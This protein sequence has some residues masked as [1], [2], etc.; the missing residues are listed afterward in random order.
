MKSRFGW[1]LATLAIMTFALGQSSAAAGQMVIAKAASVTLTQAAAVRA[2][3]V[4]AAP[5]SATDETKVPHYFGPYPNW[6][7]SPQVLSNAVVDI[8]LGTPTPVS[9]GNPLVERAFATDF[10]TTPG[11]LGPVF[12]VLP[13]AKL[14]AG[15]LQSFQYWNQGTAAGSPNTSAGNLFH[16]YVLRPSAVANEYTVIY[17]SGVQTVPAPT[18]ATGE[19]ET[20]PVAPPIAVAADDVIGLYGEGIPVDTGVTVNPDSLS[21]P[22]S[23]DA[24][25]ATNVAP[26]QDSTMTLGVTTGFPL[27]SQDRTYSFAAT[28][29]PTITDPGTGAAAA[30]TVDPKTGAISAVTVTS[31]G[32]G[33]VVE[34]TVTIGS[35]GVT[36]SAIATAKSQISL[37]VITSIAVNETGFGFVAPEVTITGGNPTTPATFVASGGVDNLTLTNAGS[38]YANQPLVKISLPDLPDGVQATAIATMDA[39]GVVT[40]IEVANAGS[41]YTQA[42]TVSI[43]DAG[44]IPPTTEATA[45][46]TIGIAKIDITSGGTGYDSA[47]TVTIADTV[48]TADKGA[49]A[50]ATVAVKGAVTGITVTA[51]GAGYLTPGLKKFVDTLPGLGPTATNNL[52]EYIPV[53][54]PDTTTYPGT[55]YYEI[56]L[57][58]YRHKFHTDV[59]AT[60]VRGYVQL[61]TTVVPGAHLALTNANL[62]P[63]VAAT[64]A[65]LPPVGTA[66]PLPAF[67]VDNPHYLG[68]TI[69]ATKD[70]PTRITF[71]NLLPTGE[72]G[73]LF[74][75]VDTSMMGSGMGPDGM[76]LDPV[77]KVPMDHATDEGT[78]LDEVRNPMCAKTPKPATCFAE[79]RA[80]L[81]LHGGITPWISDGTPH[82]WITPAGE[83]TAYPKGVSVSNVP[84]MPDPGPGAQTFFYTNQ[85]SARLMFYH[86]HAWGITRLNVY[87]GEAGG[88]L[89]TDPMEQ[90]L[91]G[92]GGALEGLGLGDPLIV[93]DKTFVPSA[94]TMA[95]Q[96]PTWDAAKWGGEGNLWTPHVYMPAQNPGDPSGMSSFGRWMYGPWFWPPAKDAK[97]PPISNPYFDPACDPD[98]QPFCEPAL[99]PSTPNVSVGMEAFNDTPIVNG[100]AYPKTTV[101]PKAYRYRVLNAANDRFWNLS[102]YVADPTTGTLSE[103]ALNQAEVEAAQTDPVVFPTPDTTKSPKGPSWIQIGTEGGFLPA[104]AVVPAQPTTWITDPTRFDV[105]NVDQHS[106]LLAPAERADVIVDFSAYRGK[107]LILYNDAPAAFPARVPGY[108]YYTGGPDLTP[109]GA[110]STLPGY[111]PNTRT[112][113][114]VKVSTAA[115]AIA[116]DRPNTTADRLGALVAAFAHKADGSG[117]FESSQDPVIVGQDAYDATY[118]TNFAATGYCNSPS[119]PTAKCDGYARINQQGGD[120]FKFD[121]LG[122]NKD[123]TGPQLSIPIQPKGIHDEMNSANFDEWGRMTANMGLEAPGA[124]PLLQNIILYPY[125]NPATETLDSTGMPSSLDVTPI[126]SAADGTQIWKITHNGVDTHPLHFHL[127]NVQ[128]LN[129][130]TWDNIIIPPEPTELG[131]KETVRVSPLEDTIVAV[132]P[133]VPTLPFGVPDSARPLNPMMPIGA[134]GAQNGVNGNE[135]GFNN[136]DALGNPIAPIINT[137]VNMDWEY[138][139]HCHIL[140]H[141][142]MDMMRPVTVHVA[143]ALPAA[144][145]LSNTSGSILSWTDGTPVDYANPASWTL[146]GPAVGTAEVG[147]RVERAVVT[148]GVA[149]AYTQIGVAL[150]NSTTF[151]DN[152]PDPTATHAYR[153]IAWN[154]AGDSTSNVI[155]VEGLPAAPTGL[156]A[157]LQAAPALP[158]GAQ[159]A[160]AWTNN[161]TNAT[162][163][164]VER[165]VGTGT[166]SVLATLAPS[167]TAYIDTTVVPG[168]YS[169]RVKAVGPVGPSGYAG[170][171]TLTV[172]QAG[173]TT[174]VL[175]SPNP[176]LVGQDVTFTATVSPVLATGTPTGTVTF[177]ADGTVTSVPVDALG[178]ATLTTSVLPAGTHTIT[179]GYGG[180]TVF[181]PSSGS[182]TQQVD[183]TASS[184]VVVSSANP[185]LAGQNV[186]F[187]A[188][189]SPSA[190]TGTVQFTIDGVSVGAPVVLAAGQ[191]T[192]ST[193]TLAVGAHPVTV[194]YGGDAAYLTSTSPTLTQSVGSA[195][196]ATTTVVT[197]NRVPSANLGQ[198]ITFTATVRPVAGTGI[199]SGTVQFIIDGINVGGLRPL[200]AQG[201]ATYPTSVL[202]AG[203]HNVIAVYGGSAILAGGGSPTFIQVVNQ[204][205]STTVVTSSRNPSVSGQSVTLTARVTPL[206][207]SGTVQ[208]RLDGAEVGGPVALDATGRARLVTN[209][210]AVGAHPVSAVYSGNV[211]YRP[212]TSANLTQTVNKASSRTVLVGTGSPATL[213]T[214]VVFT[215]TVTARAPGS[216]IPTGTVQFRIDGV[217]AGAPVAL[218]PSGQAAY[219]TNS[220]RVGL[221]TVAAVFS[222]DGS[223]ITSTSLNLTQRIR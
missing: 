145:L 142:E 65:V 36:P 111:G 215:A 200:S 143:R 105:G 118:G 44:L 84:D 20:L 14:P 209:A 43:V 15:L 61:S 122:P 189:V 163:V 157:E 129:R 45:T 75:P 175:S 1:V 28:V 119:N 173:S 35:P 121:T 201:R 60:L 214:T 187:T 156:T 71:R 77:T 196:R 155:T 10:L 109:A 64:P 52:G 131:W 184:T 120:L 102:W 86:D 32:S 150:A 95:K 90:S 115:P 210:L 110:P 148:D 174:V 223:F 104:P 135:A 7:N 221:H 89:L 79:D 19:V 161:A 6:A 81:H 83:N 128:V 33:Y 182:T 31:P 23:A 199:P 217:N 218:N 212:S 91:I 203:S 124:T 93:Q 5:T 51:P 166:F 4:A 113:M 98:V 169:Y 29:T 170:P 39:N 167:D 171:V 50:T 2:T 179:A 222:G 11:T 126:S 153:V 191:A 92:A 106:L 63:A 188:T 158:A 195:L 21:Y 47:P 67:G 58:Q 101:D 41:G 117:V 114:Q 141:E 42:P 48:G 38:G 192:F 160:L 82:Q 216:G 46:A 116:F 136:T 56:G 94:A 137:V 97:Y 130:V 211:N 168:D 112:V 204:A 24:T 78:V 53:A 87:A 62:D 151:T 186:T 99:I 107:T 190:T 66:A 73:E 172:S 69:V 123:G 181:L 133:I 72:A 30:A 16:A 70:R 176:S 149:G 139:W 68:P 205:A 88:Y 220:L 193:S 55:D 18:V 22:A 202:P 103:V 127:Y 25:L 183:K 80:T 207:A 219:P 125:T 146:T 144:P 132:R 40:S 208:F 3:V 197:S 8:G 152:P 76:M 96:D 185:S 12:V 194:T 164:V 57:V 59:P 134:R 49:S 74:L 140:S 206:A 180:D 147:Y 213:G 165:A 162:G 178:S 85:Q 159:V 27:Y 13:H 154:A 177:T 100:T 9:V 54:V 108:D 26:A 34:P 138:V 37:G 17:D 198:S